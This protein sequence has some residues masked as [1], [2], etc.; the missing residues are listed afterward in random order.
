MCNY[1]GTRV[2]R[3]STGG[4]SSAGE[5]GVDQRQVDV[6]GSSLSLSLLLIQH[7]LA[8][9]ALLAGCASC[10]PASDP[11]TLSDPRPGSAV[12]KREFIFLSSS[13]TS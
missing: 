7:R 2:R 5:N 13:L 11:P 8:V 9:A 3:N 4:G 6:G 1:Y 10:S 12:E